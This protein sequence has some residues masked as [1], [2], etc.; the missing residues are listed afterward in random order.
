[1]SRIQSKDLFIGL[2]RINKV[3]L[4]SND[5]KKIYT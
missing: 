2:H 5:D 3:A 4:F 1:M